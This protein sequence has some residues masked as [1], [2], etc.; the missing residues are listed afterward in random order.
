MHG[1]SDHRT[2]LIFKTLDEFIPKLGVHSKLF[3]R[4][5]TDL[6]SEYYIYIYIYMH[7]I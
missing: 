7:I 3:N 1:F 4:L 2:L 6:Y 5:R